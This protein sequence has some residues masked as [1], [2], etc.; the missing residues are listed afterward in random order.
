M[1]RLLLQQD[2]TSRE[3]VVLKVTKDDD[4]E[5]VLGFRVDTLGM[6]CHILRPLTINEG[7]DVKRLVLF[8]GVGVD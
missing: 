5:A 1:A 6:L 2:G 3:L 7:L 8:D 4:N